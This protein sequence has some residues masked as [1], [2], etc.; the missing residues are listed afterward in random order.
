[1]KAGIPKCLML[2][3]SDTPPASTGNSELGRQLTK[4]CLATE[5]IVQT[6]ESV[7]QVTEL[8]SLESGILRH[9][10]QFSYDGRYITYDGRKID[11]GNR[12]FWPLRVSDTGPEPGEECVYTRGLRAKD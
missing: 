11:Q 6:R 12:Y 2:T 7:G 8:T 5:G 10:D 3:F 4:I 1:P 9:I